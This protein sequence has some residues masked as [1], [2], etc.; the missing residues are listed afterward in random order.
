VKKKRV[1]HKRTRRVAPEQEGDLEGRINAPE[2]KENLRPS[3]IIMML[4]RT[5]PICRNA[6]NL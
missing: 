4:W 1:S 6:W 2:E 3:A 5:E